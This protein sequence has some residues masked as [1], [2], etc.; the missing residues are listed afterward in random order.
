MNW[1]QVKRLATD[2]LSESGISDGD[3]EYARRLVFE[4]EEIEK[5]ATQNYWVTAV[6]E[7]RKFT[8][9]DHGLVLPWILGLTDINPVRGEIQHVVEYKADFPD[10]DIDFLPSAREKIKA[11]ATKTYGEDCVCNVGSWITYQP[12]A[13]LHDAARALG[14]GVKESEEVTNG[15]PIEFNNLSPEQACEEY[16]DVKAFAERFPDVFEMAYKFVDRIKTQGKHAGGLIISSVPLHDH[17]PLTMK[18]GQWSSAWTEGNSSQLSTFGFVK[19]DLLGV[20]T[21]SYIYHC[22]QHLAERGIRIEIDDD[23][24]DDRAGWVYYPDREREKIRYSDEAALAMANEAKT[25]TVFQLDTGLARS[26]IG[27]GGVT[28]FN[29]LVVYTALGRPGPLPQIKP[30]IER[31]D[32]KDGGAWRREDKRITDILAKTFNVVVFQEQLTQMWQGLAGMTGPEAQAALKVVRKKHVDKLPALKKQWIDGATKTIGLAEAERWWDKFETFG[33]YAFVASHSLGYMS[34]AFQCLWLK[35]HFPTEWWAACIEH[36]PTDPKKNK[37]REYMDCARRE[38]IKFRNIDVNELSGKYRVENGEVIPSITVIK[39]IGLDSV[40]EIVAENE[41]HQFESMEQFIERYNPGK[42]IMERLIKLGAFSSLPG[43]E[44]RR[45]LWAWWQYQHGKDPD[46]RMIRTQ[47]KWSLCWPKQEIEDQRARDAETYLSE[48][49]RRKL[50]PSR[51]LNWRPTNPWNK[52]GPLKEDYPTDS[53][54]PNYKLCAK[55]KATREDV[56]R[57]FSSDYSLDE[58]LQIESEYLGFYIHD[59]MH[60]FKTDGGKDV[61]S[62]KET[63]ELECIVNE[64]SFRESKKGNLYAVMHV[65]DGFS[66]ANIM[67]WESALAYMDERIINGRGVGI[68]VYVDWQ[69]E[70]SNFVLNEKHNVIHIL[71][72]ADATSQ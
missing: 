68:R 13:A 38:G 67:V 71:D 41:K 66:R 69:P 6:S 43:H 39:G 14:H 56:F 5:Q 57:L 27:Q 55:I 48:G 32:G 37:R 18:D 31:R 63:G 33:K 54:D 24:E 34:I 62:A 35:A 53:R 46:A 51:I 58:T 30:Y 26:I 9:N 17:M 29:D 3:S 12:M 65:T 60:L 52:P 16:S 61:E 40:P 36:C 4:F 10:I 72:L 8:H 47:I 49:K 25:D 44:N 50:V 19:F 21:L 11:Y 15:L 20:T 22:Q 59:P 64:V 2:A 7:G 28:G 45:A 1:D 70:F 42:A 23:P